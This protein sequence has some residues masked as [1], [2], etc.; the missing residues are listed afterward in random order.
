[1]SG[2]YDE[3]IRKYS[4]SGPTKGHDDSGPQQVRNQYY[5]NADVYPLAVSERGTFHTDTTEWLKHSKKAVGKDTLFEH[6]LIEN[7]M[8]IVYRTYIY[9][10]ENVKHTAEIREFSRE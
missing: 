4:R 8:S 9:A 5:L 7:I 10:K 1:M 3:K 2:H 6:S